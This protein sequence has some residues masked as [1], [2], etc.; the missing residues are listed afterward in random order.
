[1]ELRRGKGGVNL[2]F[3]GLCRLYW[4]SFVKITKNHKHKLCSFGLVIHF[5]ILKAQ[6]QGEYE[7]WGLIQIHWN[8]FG[9]ELKSR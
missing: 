3:R 7:N 4:L 9:Y 1:M 5:P 2:E 6:A 8:W